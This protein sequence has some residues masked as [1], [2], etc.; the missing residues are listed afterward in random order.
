MIKEE[1]AAS[2]INFIFLLHKGIQLQVTLNDFLLRK[3]SEI[4]LANRNTLFLSKPLYFKL[5][6]F[7]SHFIWFQQ[8]ASHF[9]DCLAMFKCHGLD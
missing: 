5:N 4:A 6:S 8:V 1:V 7:S 9:D 3:I 2:F